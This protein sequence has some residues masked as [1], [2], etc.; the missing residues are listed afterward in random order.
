[1][2]ALEARQKDD[3]LQTSKS[4]NELHDA[5]QME[6]VGARARGAPRRTASACALYDPPMLAPGRPRAP[7]QAH[8][9]A[10]S[11][12]NSLATTRAHARQIAREI[13]EER[14][15][16][17]LRKIESAITLD[18]NFERK[19]QPRRH[20]RPFPCSCPV[21]AREGIVVAL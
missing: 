13:L 21:R 8:T 16:K 1:V 19:V 10:L 17:E 11:P 5:L 3:T 4:V 6:Q 7:V 18:I 14:K 20:P 12:S 15:S 2:Q 9:L